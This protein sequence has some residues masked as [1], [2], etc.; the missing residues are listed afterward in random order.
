MS[1][2]ILFNFFLQYLSFVYSYW[3]LFIYNYKIWVKY[4]MQ[5][6]MSFCTS[7]F[8]IIILLKYLVAQ[9]LCYNWNL[10]SKMVDCCLIKTDIFFNVELNNWLDI[11]VCVGP[12]VTVTLLVHISSTFCEIIGH[13]HCFMS[14]S[15]HCQNSCLWKFL[16]SDPTQYYNW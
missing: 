6:S 4:K 13:L 15:D 9:I 16:L 11:C 8:Y 5:Y 14:L 3:K 10:K 12:I 2:I 1:F 7:Y